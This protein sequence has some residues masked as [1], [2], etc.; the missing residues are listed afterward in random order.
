MMVFL[1]RDPGLL[2]LQNH[3]APD[4]LLG[5]HGRNREVA[6]LVTRLV[7]EIGS[8]P[9]RVP[10]SLVGINEVVAAVAVLVIAGLIKDEELGLGPPV[11]DIADFGALEI[12]LSL[13]GD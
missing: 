8:L 13:Q 7:A 4:V 11:G 6:L 10:D 5:V 3:L 12:F 9:P 1:D 2:H